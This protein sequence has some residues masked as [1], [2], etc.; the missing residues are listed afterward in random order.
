M[1]NESSLFLTSN[2]SSLERGYRTT[3]LN[4]LL[5]ILYIRPR[6]SSV[7]LLASSPNSE[8]LASRYLWSNVVL[9]RILN[10]SPEWISYQLASLCRAA[11]G[12]F[13]ELP[14]EGELLICRALQLGSAT[15]YFCTAAIGSIHCWSCFSPASTMGMH[16][17]LRNFRTRA[18]DKRSSF[19]F[20]IPH[21][22]ILQCQRGS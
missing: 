18:H 7:S 10:P 22:S 1:C 2:G 12:V 4:S 6:L 11:V 13:A 14:L 5:A 8:F 15:S 21:M 17:D 9:K 3:V 19:S 16:G 20:P